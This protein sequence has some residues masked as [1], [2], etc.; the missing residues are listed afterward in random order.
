[1]TALGEKG[2]GRV[3]IDEDGVVRGYVTVLLRALMR[4]GSGRGVWGG[5]HGGGFDCQRPRDQQ[6]AAWPSHIQPHT[7]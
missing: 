3:G 2:K 7:R 5:G 6:E 1:M 4:E